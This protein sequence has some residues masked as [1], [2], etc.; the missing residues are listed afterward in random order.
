[1]AA[2]FPVHDV[3][4]MMKENSV[5][6]LF[7]H[8]FILFLGVGVYKFIGELLFFL[9]SALLVNVKEEVQDDIIVVHE[10]VAPARCW[11]SNE[12]PVMSTVTTQHML[13]ETAIIQKENPIAGC[14]IFRKFI[15]MFRSVFMWLS[16]LC[17]T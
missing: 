1:V 2:R 5:K 16:W 17:R 12:S 3:P 6:G 7:A 8:I 10:K 9:A 14:F 13:F 11:S 15:W 4:L